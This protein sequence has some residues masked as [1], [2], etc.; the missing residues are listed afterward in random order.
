MKLVSV[1]FLDGAD[2]RKEAESRP[3]Y[4]SQTL[5][6]FLVV[7]AIVNEAKVDFELLLCEVWGSVEVMLQAD[8]GIPDEGE[9]L[10]QQ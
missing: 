6:E 3:E 2:W 1:E 5:A 10:V 4:W 7:S 8:V 9:V